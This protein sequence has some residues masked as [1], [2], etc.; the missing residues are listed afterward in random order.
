LTGVAAVKK[1]VEQPG[2]QIGDSITYDSGLSILNKQYPLDR[3][4][5]KKIGGFIIASVEKLSDSRICI[6]PLPYI[7][8]ILFRKKS[9]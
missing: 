6:S 2:M 5:D 9:D 4:Q 7:S 8:P 3:S 1:E